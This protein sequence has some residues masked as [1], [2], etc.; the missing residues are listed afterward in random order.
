[1]GKTLIK[2]SYFLLIFTLLLLFSYISKAQSYTNNFARN[3]NIN[4]NTNVNTNAD[5]NANANV[6]DSSKQRSVIK[7]D[8][9]HKLSASQ[10][11]K[12]LLKMQAIFISDA[13]LSLQEL[14]PNF[15]KNFLVK[16]K[17]SNFAAINYSNADK[18]C[19][20]VLMPAN[21]TDEFPNANYQIVES[22]LHEL[23]H[24][25]LGKKIFYSGISWKLREI[26]LLQRKKINQKWVNKTQ[27][28]LTQIGCAK[29]FSACLLMPEDGSLAPLLWYHETY[30][31]VMASLLF[32]RLYPEHSQGMLNYRKK[33]REKDRLGI[34][35]TH[36]ALDLLSKY[37]DITR[38]SA[39][40]Y[41]I[42]S[43]AA[44]KISQ[45]G[46]LLSYQEK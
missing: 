40:T 39:G 26:S 22:F 17:I 20:I 21:I 32:S 38:L 46:L 35:D 25:L 11:E 8:I 2:K 23:S 30:A 3:F 36:M 28:T 41:E 7:I 1:M 19:N 45:T 15:P 29:K 16:V 31:D 9:L 44:E 33:E 34:H 12:D 27:K 14:V 5:I 4:A 6:S 18:N 10:K 43:E 42:I 13:F 37:E 24:C